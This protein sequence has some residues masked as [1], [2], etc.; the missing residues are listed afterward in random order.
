M[1]REDWSQRMLHRWGS[2]GLVAVESGSTLA[3]VQFAP[4]GSLA[5]V[6]ALPGGSAIPED[7]ALLHCLLVAD[8][9]PSY[10][11]RRL[12]HRALGI[13]HKRGVQIVYAFAHPLGSFEAVSSRNLC[14]LEFL[15]ANGFQTVGSYGETHLMS[16][17]LHGLLPAF[18]K[19]ARSWLRLRSP[20]AAPTPVAFSQ[21]KDR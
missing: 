1:S 11:A 19:P 17:Q 12:L 13:L 15:G 18:A 16:I 4:A 21:A 20:V 2:V 14:G 7:Q 10:H 8:G 9:I 5:R 3:A 6:A